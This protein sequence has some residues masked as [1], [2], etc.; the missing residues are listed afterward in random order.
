MPV[1]ITREKILELYK[2]CRELEKR[3]HLTS[4]A[5]F[6]FLKKMI[7]DLKNF[8]GQHTDK[9]SEL[10]RHISDQM[11]LQTFQNVLVPLERWLNKTVRDDEFLI[12][13]SDQKK[14]RSHFPLILV[15]DHIR[16]AFNVGAFFRMADGLG[17]E[18]I[19]LSGYTPTPTQLS[20]QKTSMGSE[21]FVTWEWV[22]NLKLFLKQHHETHHV[23]AWETAERAISCDTEFPQRP[24]IFIFGNERFG[25]G[26]DLLELC[27]EVRS[28]DM[29]G[30][31][32]S[33]NVAQ[34]AAVGVFEWRRQWLQ[35]HSK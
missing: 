7:L 33:M 2:H 12:R 4:P 6:H 31:K 8:E 3:F 19:I 5:D 35:S 14:N 25:L 18:K 23:V 28:I 22:E 34:A 32:N 1:Q 13:Q 17:A 30:F 9:L 21:D 16:S 15:L 26:P 10:S 20:V 29:M 27:H 24:T 11:S